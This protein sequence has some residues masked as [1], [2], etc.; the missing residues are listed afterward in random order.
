VKLI[1]ICQYPVLSDVNK[2]AVKAYGIGKGMLGFVSVARVTV[3]V[4]KRGIIR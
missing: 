2:E 4:D 1:V 3:I